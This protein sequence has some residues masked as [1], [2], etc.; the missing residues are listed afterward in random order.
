[1]SDSPGRKDQP[2]RRTQVS[3]TLQQEYRGE[4]AACNRACGV[5]ILPATYWLC[6]FRQVA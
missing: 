1:M 4:A 2:Q 5:Q 6:D 3:D